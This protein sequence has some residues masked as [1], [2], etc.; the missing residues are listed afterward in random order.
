MSLKKHAIR[1]WRMGHIL[2]MF[3]TL[4]YHILYK[5]VFPMNKIKYK[6]YIS[7]IRWQL[8]T[9][10]ENR[11]VMTGVQFGIC[12]HHYHPKLELKQLSQTFSHEL[13]KCFVTWVHVLQLHVYSNKYLSSL[14]KLIWRH[15]TYKMPVRYI[16]SSVWVRLSIFF[17]IIHCT[18]YGAVC[19]QFTH[20]PYDDWENIYF[21]LLS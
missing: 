13:I 2:Q 8:H 18:L 9:E 19:F 7:Q 15:W 5:C 12:L 16:L 11:V 14:C 17:S 6:N 10:R 1:L 20:L 4:Q 3:H 21:V